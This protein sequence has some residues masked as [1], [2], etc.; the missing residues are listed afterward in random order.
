MAEV[1]YDKIQQ[2]WICD[3]GEKM[4]SFSAGMETYWRYIS[5]DGHQLVFYDELVDLQKAKDDEERFAPGFPML[6]RVFIKKPTLWKD[7]G[8]PISND[9]LQRMEN[10]VEA[11]L[12]K[13]GAL[14]VEFVYF[15]I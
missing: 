11:A 14:K 10:F 15:G 12:I 8:D 13:R 9:E 2:T 5:A 7:N 3:S 1:T 4:D 6:N